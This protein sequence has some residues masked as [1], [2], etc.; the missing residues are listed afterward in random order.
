MNRQ[1]YTPRARLLPGTS[2]LVQAVSSDKGA[3]G[4]VGLGYVREAAEKVKAIKIK[5]PQ[6]AEA[7]APSEQSVID[8]SYP[9]ARPLFLYTNGEPQGTAKDFIDFALSAPGQKIVSEAGYVSMK[10]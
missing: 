1:D 3:I 7:I 2:A 5:S 10:R 4:Y 8:G 9:I 6:S